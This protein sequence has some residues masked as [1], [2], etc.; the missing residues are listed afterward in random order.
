MKAEIVIHALEFNS[1]LI[2]PFV[3][4]DFITFG[5]VSLFFGLYKNGLPTAETVWL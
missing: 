1:A 2:Q 4:E 5:N 3:L